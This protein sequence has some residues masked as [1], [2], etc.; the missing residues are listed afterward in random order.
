MTDDGSSEGVGPSGAL[1][2]AADRQLWPGCAQ[3]V[4]GETSEDREVFRAVILAVAGLVFVEADIEHPVQAVLDGPVRAHGVCEALGGARA[5]A[6]MERLL[7][8]GFAV[9]VRSA[10]TAK[11]AAACATISAQ[12]ASPPSASH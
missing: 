5:E 2:F 1:A 6:R 3:H 8:P 9:K 11:P 7:G 10:S 12:T 4:E